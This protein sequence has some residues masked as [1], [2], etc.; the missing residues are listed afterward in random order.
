[1]QS[2]ID[3]WGELM[4]VVGAEEAEAGADDEIDAE[5]INFLNTLEW[6]DVRL[7]TWLTPPHR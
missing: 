4:K 7:R 2:V 5:L 3:Y 6:R 1:M